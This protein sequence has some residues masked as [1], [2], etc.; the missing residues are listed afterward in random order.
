MD[1]GGIRTRRLAPRLAS[2]ASTAYQLALYVMNGPCQGSKLSHFAPYLLHFKRPPPLPH[3]TLRYLSNSGRTEAMDN[4]MNSFL[5]RGEPSLDE[6]IAYVV[7][8]F[9]DP[10]QTKGCKT[11]LRMAVSQIEEAYDVSNEVLV[12]KLGRAHPELLRAGMK[13]LTTKRSP[14]EHKAMLKHLVFRPCSCHCCVVAAR[15]G[16]SLDDGMAIMEQTVR[17]MVNLLNGQIDK[18]HQHKFRS[19][20]TDKPADAQ[21]WPQGPNDLLPS[22]VKDSIDAFIQWANGDVDCDPAIFTLVGKLSTFYEPFAKAVLAPPFSL[23]LK[24]P[25]QS[26]ERA[27]KRKPNPTLTPQENAALFVRDARG[28]TSLFNSFYIAGKDA[29]DDGLFPMGEWAFPIFYRAEKHLLS[30]P[31]PKE[32]YRDVL[33]RLGDYVG[34]YHMSKP[35]SSGEGFDFQK[36]F[37][38]DGIDEL[39]EAFHAM[40]IAK[41]GMCW[42]AQCPSSGTG[43][44][45]RFCSQCKFIRYCSEECQREAWKS[46]MAPHKPLCLAI[47]SLKQQIGPKGWDEMWSPG[48]GYERFKALCGKQQVDMQLVKAVGNGLSVVPMVRSMPKA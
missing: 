37:N 7:A 27:M 6:A 23:A 33:R 4:F 28:V 30:L 2:S 17:V 43:V 25:I 26:L 41:K 19:A 1:R 45:A 38:P 8:A 11:Q 20:H 29:F 18:L 16:F 35:A 47:C 14:A 3:T 22:G 15:V 39:E 10:L 40:G 32:S 46:K 5:T 34:L 48:F 13:F 31:I 42:N 44:R 12:Y 24:A 9:R 36:W 21:F